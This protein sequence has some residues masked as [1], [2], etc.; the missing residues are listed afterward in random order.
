MSSFHWLQK[1]NNITSKDQMF[2][3]T[4]SEGHLT[5]SSY[6][7]FGIARIYWPSL[8]LLASLAHFYW[9]RRWRRPVITNGISPKNLTSNWTRRLVQVE[10]KIGWVWKCACADWSMCRLEYD[11]SGK[12]VNSMTSFKSCPRSASE[13]ISFWAVEHKFRYS[14]HINIKIILVS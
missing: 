11:R 14:A 12:E 5:E 10:V 1:Q 8:P 6:L 4:P 7:T 13:P 9:Y 2:Q 3:M